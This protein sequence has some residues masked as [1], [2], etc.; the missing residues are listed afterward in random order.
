MIRVLSRFHSAITLLFAAVLL[1]SGAAS[2]QTTLRITRSVESPGAYAPGETV[3]I[4][5]TIIRQGGGNQVTQLG[6]QETL[7]SGWSFEGLVSGSVPQIPPASGAKGQLNFGW[8][9]IPNSFPASFVYRVRASAASSGTK[10]ISGRV[11]YAIFGGSTTNSSNVVTL[12]SQQEGTTPVGEDPEEEIPGN[13]TLAVDHALPGNGSYVPG[14]SLD[15]TVSIT[16]TN[17][18]Q[19]TQLGLIETLPEGWSFDRIVSGNLPGIQPSTGKTGQ[20]SF[21]WLFI[22][23]FPVSLT[24]RVH[25]PP[26]SSGDQL[27]RG[28]AIFSTGGAQA[29]TPQHAINIP[30]GI[31][32][33]EGEE[34]EDTGNTDPNT[35]V[36]LSRVALNNGFYTPGQAVSLRVT[37]DYKGS[38]KVQ[39]LGLEELTPPG[40]TFGGFSSGNIPPIAPQPGATGTLGFAYIS[41][42]NFPITFTYQLFATNNS[43]G[44][45]TVF[46]QGLYAFTDSQKRTAIFPTVIQST[47]EEGLEPGLTMRRLVSDESYVPGA[48]MDVTVNLTFVGTE[49]VTTLGFEETLPGNWTFVSVQSANP[50]PVSPQPGERGTLAFAWIDPPEMPVAVTYRV[51]V[52]NESNGEQQ[53]A[54]LARYRTTGNEL[55]SNEEVTTIAAADL[56]E[57]EGEGEGGFE[58]EGEGAEESEMIVMDRTVLTGAGYAPGDIVDIRLTV[59]QNQPGTLLAFGI[60]EI[61]PPG[62]SFVQVLDQTLPPIRPGEGDRE[63]INFA[64]II[65]PTLPLN[66]T[67]RLRADA[68]ATGDKIITGKVQYRLQ[69]PP[70]ESPEEETIL[71]QLTPADLTVQSVDVPAV[72]YTGRTFP[73]VATILNQGSNGVSPPLSDCL[74]ISTDNTFGGDTQIA[75]FERSVRVS[76]NSLYYLQERL[77]VPGLTPGNYFLFVRTDDGGTANES[78][79]DNNVSQPIPIRIDTVNY[80]VTA[81]HQIRIVDGQ[82]RIFIRGNANDFFLG[83]PVPQAPVE[84]DLTLHGVTRVYTATTDNIGRYEI[85]FTPL[86]TEAGRF[87]IAGRHP[88]EESPAPEEDSF[89]LNLMRIEYNGQIVSLAPNV[90][91]IVNASVENLGDTPLTSLSVAV[92][93]VPQGISAQASLD[94]TVEAGQTIPLTI[95]LVVAD[96]PGANGVM[97]VVVTN[98]QNVGST[99]FLPFQVLD[100]VPNFVV[101]PQEPQP[102]AIPGQQT[103]YEFEVQNIG[104]GSAVNFQ[105]EP[106]TVPWVN[107]VAPAAPFNLRAQE[108]ARIILQLAPPASQPLGT[109]NSSIA[110]LF[111]DDARVNLPLTIA[112]VG[113]DRGGLDIV[114]TDEST[115]TTNPSFRV[116][117][118]NVLLRDPET[119]DMVIDRTTTGSGQAQFRNIPQGAYNIEAHAEGYGSFRDVVVIDA[120]AIGLYPIVLQRNFTS[121][122]WLVEPTAATNA[123]NYI[124]NTEVLAGAPGPQVVVEPAVIDLE[125]QFEISTV[126]ELTISNDGAEPARNVR[127]DLPNQTNFHFTPLVSSLGDLA[128]GASLTVPV[129]VTRVAPPSG[130]SVSCVLAGPCAVSY[131]WLRGN[132]PVLRAFPIAV[133][134][135]RVDCPNSRP[136]YGYLPLQRDGAVPYAPL[137]EFT[138]QVV[139]GTRLKSLEPAAVPSAEKADPPAPRNAGSWWEKALS[140]LPGL[141]GPQATA[142]QH[143]SALQLDAVAAPTV[144]AGLSALLDWEGGRM[145]AALGD[146]SPKLEASVKAST[147]RTRV[148]EP[149]D[150]FLK[151]TAFETLSNLRFD[152]RFFDELELN[153][154]PAFV[155]HDVKLLN[156]ANISNATVNAGVTATARLHYIPD[157]TAARTRSKLYRVEPRLRFTAGGVA[158]TVNLLPLNLLVDVQKSTTLQIFT[159]PA[160]LGDDPSTPEVEPSHDF[161]TAISVYNKGTDTLR[162]VRVR[163]FEPTLE[164]IGSGEIDRFEAL[165]LRDN[166]TTGTRP[167]L[168]A[169]FGDLG[170]NKRETVVWNLLPE[171]S[172]E[173]A[174]LLSTIT[175]ELPGR[176]RRVLLPDEIEQY[177]LLRALRLNVGIDDGKPDLLVDTNNDGQPDQVILSNTN[178]VPISS[179]TNIAVTQSPDDPNIYN[180]TGTMPFFA[181]YMEIPLP[182]GAD[183]NLL[184]VEKSNT[185]SLRPENVWVTQ[186]PVPVEG[187]GTE[188]RVTV[189][190]VD[191]SSNGRYTIYMGAGQVPNE[192]PVADAGG[193]KVVLAGQAIT[194][195][196]RGSFDPEDAPLQYLWELVDKPA[197]ST[198]TITNPTSSAAVFSP[199]LRGDYRI[200]LTVSDGVKTNAD[201]IR[202]T[203]A[204]NAPTARTSGDLQALTGATVTLDATASTDPESDPLSYSWS[205]ITQPAGSNVSITS[206]NSATPT[207]T[208][209]RAGNYVFR[210]SVSDGGAVA[211]TAEQRLTVTNRPPIANAGPDQ[212]L[213]VG[214]RVQLDGSNSL[215]PDGGPLTYSWTFVSVPGNSNA[216]LQ[217]PSRATSSFIIDRQGDYV[218]QLTVSDGISSAVDEVN[219]STSNRAPIADAGL[220]KSAQVGTSV[221]LDGSQSFD[222]DGDNIRFSW[223]LI[224]RPVGSSATI[225]GITLERPTLNIDVAGNYTAQLIVS[226]G[227]LNSPPATVT[228]STG[229]TP[230][231]ANAGPDQ[232]ATVGAQ[233]IL[234]GSASSDADGDQLLYIWSFRSRP[235]GSNAT[236]TS[237]N[238]VNPRFTVDVAG[239]YVVELRTFDGRATSAP[240]TVTISTVNSAPTAKAGADIAAR[241]GETVRLDGGESTDPDGDEI[242]YS[243]T[244][245]ERPAGSTAT[246]SGANT[247]TPSF[248]V[249]VNGRYVVRLLVSDGTLTSQPASVIINTQNSPPAANAGPDQ[250]GRVGQTIQLDGSGSRDP[251]GDPLTYAWTFTSVPE[252]SSTGIANAS[253]INPSFVIDRPGTYVVSLVVNDGT[254]TSAPDTVTIT[255]ENAPPVANAGPD[256]GAAVGQTVTLDGSASSDPDFG[257]LSYQWSIVSKPAGST[258]TLGNPTDVRPT[259][260]IDEAGD[261]VVQLIVNDGELSSA[262]DTVRVST[263]NTPPVAN[264]GQDRS[265]LVG[266]TI[267]LSGTGSSDV[268]GD[269]LTYRWTI[270]SKPQGSAAVLSSNTDVSP[271]I[272]LDALGDYIIQLIVNDGLADSAP[273]TV[274]LS[275]TNTAPIARAGNNR[276]VNVGDTVQLDGTTSSD[277]DGGTLTY[278]WSFVSRP[279]GSSASL[280]NPNVPRPAFTADTAG[281]FVLQLVVNDGVLSS[282]PAQVSITAEAKPQACTA[283]P[284][285]TGVSA[286]DGTF[287]DR[288][289]VTWNPINGATGYRV[290]RADSNDVAAAAPVSGWIAA[291]S[292]SDTTAA[293]A[294]VPEGSGCQGPGAPQFTN[295]FYFVQARTGNEANCEGP[296]GGPDQGNRGIS[297]AKALGMALAPVRVPVLPANGR[298][299]QDGALFIRV[300][301]EYGEIAGFWGVVESDSGFISD[302]VAWLPVP[303]AGGNDGWVVFTPELPF[304]AGDTITFSAGGESTEGDVLGPYTYS[305]TVE[306]ESVGIRDLFSASSDSLYLLPDE[307]YEYPRSIAVPV[308]QGIAPEDARL[309]F[310]VE[311]QW[312]DAEDVIGW[313][314]VEPV[315]ET[316]DGALHLVVDVNHGGELRIVGEESLRQ[317]SASMMTAPGAWGDIIA[318]AAVAMVLLGAARRPRVKA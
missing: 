149:V 112:V 91:Q 173:M 87:S 268:D 318:A 58:G 261:Y 82:P 277:P 312:R 205:V 172:G 94:S 295:Y 70:L 162:N 131:V 285:V 286:S 130:E 163:R 92:L 236:L 24:Y 229:N 31:D 110:L 1:T 107:V 57:G 145:D 235:A 89:T 45:K 60:Q 237:P 264:A 244:L 254:A 50:P 66:I 210:V 86:P 133:R 217:T 248:V 290:L 194:L 129:A 84:V 282:A 97:R 117:G 191:I 123:P 257:T 81:A 125:M 37:L 23:T 95:N 32:E 269:E 7:P 281:S 203:V 144:D 199:D 152:L 247:A 154:T 153:Q 156:I 215:D 147:G 171:S 5:V 141:L 193:D 208:V 102:G 111:G 165:R 19:L 224:E 143:V 113:Q 246:L 142:R 120:G 177:T 263:I 221:Q 252:G 128:P 280:S 100:G 17:D 93:D 140:W 201:E 69:G 38:E 218:V 314:A 20:L 287:A 196:G 213:R 214:D 115:L 273:D 297:A 181:G 46:G 53:I 59:S 161:D 77:D 293:P 78:N 79:E 305:F 198:A 308:P 271:T 104:G 166:S 276:T 158:Q 187:G 309:Q 114:V 307:A 302:D 119:N 146:G 10:P 61:L 197:G 189:H 231:V 9:T 55:S 183:P 18:V 4:R 313:M 267:T 184:K 96:A 138:Q 75:C 270:L 253:T 101:S 13:T 200:R 64:Y 159:P 118:V 223:T 186:Q 316:I 27:H 135:P 178:P 299:A 288:V 44:E 195:E 176:G 179:G 233:V 63:A 49:Q 240:D 103:L 108:T 72:I 275:T 11:V 68:D 132:T 259:L 28:L 48:L 43:V 265:A 136:L 29:F 250:S 222:P 36:V 106:P 284:A 150:I 310:R 243:W 85:P 73:F 121:Q 298:V 56:S 35:G 301:T 148:D 47:F 260:A 228:I 116:A 51:Q 274:T 98:A 225:S 232:S 278:A 71:P 190:L 216:I 16:K 169:A 180:V 289:E 83:A 304:A 25:V 160:V 39:Q 185:S 294:V 249:D 30:E 182:P 262:P 238:I 127:L 76:P 230:P 303:G 124:S 26:G 291:T 242:T 226:D 88:G 206:P 251:D 62:F 134:L 317:S 207:V 256:I 164:E 174:Q 34:E 8:I 234:N 99:L 65:P 151:L 126:V 220:P 122:H 255:T 306:I 266:Q 292:F 279:A 22:P 192:P 175:W 42:P 209:Q 15:I 2:A 74:Y 21:A 157:L 300:A 202:I 170:T 296:A 80:G 239:T 315:L 137:P 227:S 54:G 219:I 67:Y 155:L 272:T 211:S 212:T 245:T 168:R 258:A 241:I 90:S 52:D 33:D 12:V 105:I 40:W 283:P 109:V 167:G 139:E 41:V 14:E 3:D 204:N 6:L 311:H 188:L